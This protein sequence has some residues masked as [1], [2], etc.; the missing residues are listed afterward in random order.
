[1]NNRITAAIDRSDFKPERDHRDPWG[2]AAGLMFDL[3]AYI[4]AETECITPADWGYH[5]GADP[6]AEVE[7]L[8]EYKP[9]L[10][11]AFQRA[12]TEALMRTGDV[13]SEYCDRL[14][15]NGFAY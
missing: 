12:N 8:R 15:R 13:L 14:E 1:M 5:P 6:S 10:Y 3:C 9:H 4:W 7:E 11:D 2:H